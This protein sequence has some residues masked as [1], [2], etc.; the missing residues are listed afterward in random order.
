MQLDPYVTLAGHRNDV[1]SLMRTANVFCL[2]TEM[3]PC[4][5]VFLESSAEGLPSV[6]YYSGGV[7]ELI[8]DGQ[9]GFLVYPGQIDRLAAHLLQLLQVPKLAIQLGSA[10]KRRALELFEPDLVSSRWVELL[11]GFALSKIG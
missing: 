2:P 11:S 5:L 7:P 1:R 9:T 6:A 10:A 8:L 4:P 3:D